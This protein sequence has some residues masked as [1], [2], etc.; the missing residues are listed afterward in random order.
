MTYT[1][2]EIGFLWINKKDGDNG[3]I[4][5][6]GKINGQKVVGWMKDTRLVKGPDGQPIK[7]PVTG[8]LVEEPMTRFDKKTG[9]EVPSKGFTIKLDKEDEFKAA[10]TSLPPKNTTKFTKKDKKDIDLPY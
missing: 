6:K 1:K 5:L 9:Q 3:K 2:D 4:Y 10:K 7:D 8:K